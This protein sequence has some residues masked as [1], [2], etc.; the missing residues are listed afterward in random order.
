MRLPRFPALAVAVLGMAGLAA[1]ADDRV[2]NPTY[3]SWSRFPKGTSISMR[4]TNTTAGRTSEV[5]TTTMLVEIDPEKVTLVSDSVVKDKVSDSKFPPEKRGEPRTI[6]LP[7]G[8]PKGL[9]LADF[10]ADK[11]PGVTA[12]GTEVV[13]VG[14]REVKTRWY[15]YTVD[16]DGTKLQGKRWVSAEV[17]G[18]IVKSEVK[19]L[20]AAGFSSTLRLDMIEF[21]SP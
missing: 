21:K 15:E 8:L 4:S 13:K 16:V 17:P 14:A 19:L 12:E 9:T 20:G 5:V 3:A 11:P 2:Q 6:A 18:N 10:L 1:A 7:N